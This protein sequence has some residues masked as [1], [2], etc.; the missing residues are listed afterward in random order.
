MHINNV[1]SHN[2]QERE[3]TDV[4]GF[5]VEEFIRQTKNIP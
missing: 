1:W 2:H 4:R 5:E 3:S